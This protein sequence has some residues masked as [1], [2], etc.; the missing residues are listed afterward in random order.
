MCRRCEKG[1]VGK[2]INVKSKLSFA[3]MTLFERRLGFRRSGQNGTPTT[4]PVQHVTKTWPKDASKNE[5]TSLIVAL[6]T[7]RNRIRY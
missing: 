1:I 4:L 6:A 5:T 2:Y 3:L 7:E